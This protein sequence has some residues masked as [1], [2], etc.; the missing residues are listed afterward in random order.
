[1]SHGSVLQT[2][3]KIIAQWRCHDCGE[4]HDDEDEARECCP[5]EEVYLCPSCDE[6][7]RHEIEARACCPVDPD[8]PPPMPTAQEL[9]SLGQMRLIP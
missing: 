1:M 3:K 5:P 7:Y 9:E 4:L 8:A 6:Q 2:L